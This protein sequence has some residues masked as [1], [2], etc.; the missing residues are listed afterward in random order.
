MFIEKL[1][2]II[3]EKNITMNRLAKMRDSVK[4]AQTDGK[5]KSTK[6]RSTNKSMQ[7]PKRIR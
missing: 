7:I 6:C 1:E 2:K 3:N 4:Q 5:R